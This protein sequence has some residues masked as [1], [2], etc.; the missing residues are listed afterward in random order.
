MTTNEATI[1]PVFRERCLAEYTVSARS[2]A[3]PQKITVLLVLVGLGVGGTEGQVME[4][5]CGLNPDRFDVIVCGLKDEGSMADLIRRRGIPVIALNGSGKMDFRVLTRLFSLI[6]A[7]KPDVIHSFLPFANYAAMLVGRVMNVSVLIA[8]YRAIAHTQ[9][10]IVMWGDQLVVRVAQA[11]TCCSD[12]V[13]S[14]ARSQFGGDGAKYMTIHNGVETTRFHRTATTLQKTDV[15]LQEGRVTIGTVCRLEEP[16]KGLTVLLNALAQLHQ[17]G[18]A[19]P[20]QLLLVGE[21]PAER[22]L[23]QLSEK[24]GLRDIV[25]FAGLRKDVERILP[26]LDVFVLPSLS[27]GFGIALVEAMAAG[28][29]VV[30]TS[31]GGI[32]EVVQTGAT[33]VLVPPG[34]SVALADA[35]E[36]LM[37][38]SSKAQFLGQNGRDRAT[39]LFDVSLMVRHHENLYDRLLRETHG[40]PRGVSVV[41]T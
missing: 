7:T 38:N 37:N 35:M 27:E 31:V 14:C 32:P 21:G 9:N 10:R 1:A 3:K 24:L 23:R 5:A 13:R 26:L 11:I 6:R 15:G 33:G 40:C 19:L 25:V 16:T 39:R 22:D 34:D 41:G 29:P 20:F 2:V 36:E 28:L 4:I 12:A 30:A 17:R 18:G 8:S